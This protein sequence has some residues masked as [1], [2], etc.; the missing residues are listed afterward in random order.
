MAS[1]HLQ[2]DNSICN[3]QEMHPYIAS[4]LE[5]IKGRP[6]PKRLEAFE[7]WA[8][9]RQKPTHDFTSEVIDKLSDPEVEE[10]LKEAFADEKA[11]VAVSKLYSQWIPLLQD[12]KCSFTTLAIVPDHQK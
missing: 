6:S 8:S 5:W 7:S 11:I 12:A 2:Y 1:L 4:L 9:A 10:K 3:N